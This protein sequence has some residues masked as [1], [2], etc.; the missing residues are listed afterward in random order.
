MAKENIIL[1]VRKI[2]R[3]ELEENKDGTIYSNCLAD[4]YD[5]YKEEMLANPKTKHLMDA[6]GADLSGLEK[7]M[8]VIGYCI[9]EVA[10]KGDVETMALL[11]N[12]FLNNE[13]N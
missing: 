4:V 6:F 9:Q 11:N 1:K 8:A 3:N 12:T 5:E 7:T 10:L 13:L 2:L